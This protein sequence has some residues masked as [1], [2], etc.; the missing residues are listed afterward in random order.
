MP[1][2]DIRKAPEHPFRPTERALAQV[3][4]EWVN[5]LRGDRGLA[6]WTE[7]DLHTHWRD[8]LRDVEAHDRPDKGP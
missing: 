5:E 2:L 4:L 1:R 3:L 6:L 8:R 7:D